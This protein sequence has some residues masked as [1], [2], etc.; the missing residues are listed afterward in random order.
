MELK[1]KVAIVTGSTRGIGRE[2]A[3]KLASKGA[4]IVVCA[5]KKETCDEAA[6]QISAAYQIEAIGC[7]VN[8]ADSESV[9][10]LI[11]VTL[12]KFG[13]IDI[14]VNNAGIT[15]DNLSLRMSDSEWDDVIK[16]NLNSVF[17]ATRAVL[18]PM[19]KQK[20]GRIINIASVVGLMGNVGQA[21]YAAAKGGIISFTKTIAKE[22]GAKGITANTVAP[23]FIQTDMIESLPKEYLDTIIAMIPKKGLGKPSDVANLV[24]F[25]ASDLSDY[26][27]GQV[28]QVD[29]G[30]LM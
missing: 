15:R 9:Q 5:T 2:V 8:V 18:R 6:A 12:E 13:R 25:L 1:D 3:E 28:I 20:Y 22:Y 16:T 23:G 11:K 27:T 4:K 7:Q 21:N 10:N 17:Y 30:L 19:L 14:L 26:I 24:L 29:G